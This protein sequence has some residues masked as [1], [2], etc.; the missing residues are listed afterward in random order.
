MRVPIPPTPQQE[1]GNQDDFVR[2]EHNMQIWKYAAYLYSSLIFVFLDVFLFLS[3]LFSQLE[4]TKRYYYVA[5][6]I[7]DSGRQRV[8]VV[9]CDEMV[10]QEAGYVQCVKVPLQYTPSKLVSNLSGARPP[11]AI[12]LHYVRVLRS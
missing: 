4:K 7:F 2:R 9:M 5:E 10:P 11:A 8:L 6:V 12:P 1:F 3:S